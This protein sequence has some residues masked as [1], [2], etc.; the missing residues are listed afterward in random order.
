M[1]P[2]SGPY[3]WSTWE[4]SWRPGRAGRVVLRV[5]ATDILGESQPEIP[6]QNDFQYGY[7][8]IQRIEVRVR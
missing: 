8:A 6:F 1:Y 5:R 7:N 2:G 4:T 3:D